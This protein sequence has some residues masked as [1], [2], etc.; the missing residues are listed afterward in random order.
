[1]FNE[2]EHP[3]LRKYEH[4]HTKA[5]SARIDRADAFVFV[6]PEYNFSTPPSLTNA[7]DYLLHEWAYKPAGFVSY[8]GVSGGLRAAQMT[9][10]T[11]TALKIVPLAEAVTIPFFTKFINADTGAFEAEDTQN[12]AA[13]TMLNE[14]V[15]WANALQAMRVA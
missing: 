4:E 10:L 7:L 3:R 2:P 15:K 13:Q 1:M 9:K 5:W 6:S 8:G 12:K 11:L 14:L